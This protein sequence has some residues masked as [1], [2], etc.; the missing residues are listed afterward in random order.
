[1]AHCCVNVCVCEFLM[2]RLT[3]RREATL[4]LVCE[5][6][7]AELCC[8][9]PLSSSKTRKVFYKYSPF[10][11][12]HNLLWAL[13]RDSSHPAPPW[14]GTSYDQ[15]CIVGPT[16][17]WS[18]GFCVVWITGCLTCGHLLDNRVV[19]IMGCRNNDMAS[20]KIFNIYKLKQKL[21]CAV[22]SH[23]GSLV[24]KQRNFL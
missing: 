20:I 13:E 4:P 24:F 10:T 8:S 18:S 15:G 9:S 22:W 14:S 3:L 12:Y 21:M 5:C 17:C 2:S 23:V 7:N 6:V 11:V 19:G 16:G 1:M